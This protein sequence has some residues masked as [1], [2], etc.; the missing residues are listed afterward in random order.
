MLRAEINALEGD[1]D[2]AV[3]YFF[4]KIVHRAI[5]IVAQIGRRGVM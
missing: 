2:H 3:P 4:G 5:V 1:I